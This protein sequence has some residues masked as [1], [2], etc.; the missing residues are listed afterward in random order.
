[1]KLK[2]NLIEKLTGLPAFEALVIAFAVV[3]AAS[4]GIDVRGMIAR[5][6]ANLVPALA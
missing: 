4:Y 3:K 1:M 6:A 2:F 5:E